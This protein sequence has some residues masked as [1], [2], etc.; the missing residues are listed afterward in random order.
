MTVLRFTARTLM[1][2]GLVVALAC[3]DPTFSLAATRAGA[4]RA[5]VFSAE[6]TPI[7]Y[8]STATSSHA[9]S[10]GGGGG[11]SLLRTIVGLVVVIGLIYGIA[12]VMR[13]VRKRRDGRVSGSGLASAA[14]LPLGGGRS[15]HLVRAGTELI[16]VGA[17]EHGVTPIRTYTEAEARESGL[18]GEEPPPLDNLLTAAADDTWQPAP[19]WQQPPV[20]RPIAGSS[21]SPGGLLE[22]LR[23]LTVRS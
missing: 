19:D 8:S 21:A 11:T 1:T 4:K 15:L 7:S 9:S 10:S 2:A 12:F 16:L 3:A 18:L 22:S 5:S 6:Q 23:R 13:R 17:S 20:R 14:T